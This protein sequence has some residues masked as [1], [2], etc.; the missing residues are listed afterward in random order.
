[1]IHELLQHG[2]QNAIPTA[3]LC[4]MTGMGERQ[5]RELIERERFDGYIILAGD[6]GYYLPSK[7]PIIAQLEVAGW[8]HMRILTANTIMRSATQTMQLW[9]SGEYKHE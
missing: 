8:C 6:K 7:N 3:E 5:V 1:M 9:E 4:S 2:A